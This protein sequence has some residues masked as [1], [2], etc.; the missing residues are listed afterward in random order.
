MKTNILGKI[1]HVEG[2]D[3][4]G[5]TTQ[6][7]LVVEWLNKQGYHAK[8]ARQP[9]TTKIGERMRS[10]LFDSPDIETDNMTKRLLYAASH[11]S[12]MHEVYQNKDPETIWIID[13][14]VP[15][16][17]LI[18]GAYGDELNADFV[19]NLNGTHA[20]PL[21]PD[22]I[23]IYTVTEQTMLKRIE[24][25]EAAKGDT[26]FYDF[27]DLSF[28]KRIRQGYEVVKDHLLP[29]EQ[30]LLRYLPAESG[31]EAVFEATKKLLKK[32]FLIPGKVNKL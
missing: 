26:N 28:K 27:K 8:F 6:A 32:E 3:G 9:G 13:R 16:S 2:P 21:F 14:Y 30:S 19:K 29:T 31:V 5:K 11:V 4:C 10:L 24:I 25:R 18:F 20:L 22:L 7:K 17:N 15:V 1:I 23:I 12:L